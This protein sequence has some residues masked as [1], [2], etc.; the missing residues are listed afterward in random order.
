ML[1]SKM[2]YKT[3]SPNALSLH[4]A[5]RRFITFLINL[6][7]VSVD[8]Y[9]FY[10]MAEKIGGYEAVSVSAVSNMIYFD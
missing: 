9:Q 5:K 4:S 6:L 3:L 1:V 7:F 10:C 8:L 2:I